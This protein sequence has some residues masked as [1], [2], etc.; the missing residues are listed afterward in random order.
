MV[1]LR[2]VV[3]V[4]HAGQPG[5]R[6][7]IASCGLATRMGSSATETAIAISTPYRMPTAS[8]PASAE[9]MMT[10]SPRRNMTSLVLTPSRR[11][12]RRREA[13]GVPEVCLA[14]ELQ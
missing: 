2:V 14:C 8:T 9:I 12:L 1:G 13:C 4:V 6:P 7:R 11:Q 3:H 10:I 5:T